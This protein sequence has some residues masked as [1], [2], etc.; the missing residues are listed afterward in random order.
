MLFRSTTFGIYHANNS[1]ETNANMT[2]YSDS[3]GLFI[4]NRVVSTAMSLIRNN[5]KQT[6]NSLNSNALSNLNIYIGGQNDGVG[7]RLPS[8]R[9][10]AFASIGDGLTDTE[11]SN[12]YTTVQAFQTTLSRQ[13]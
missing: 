9:E 8:N 3:R 10:C 6:D 13:V 4:N 2:D 5:V 1:S 11:A 12:F 7:V